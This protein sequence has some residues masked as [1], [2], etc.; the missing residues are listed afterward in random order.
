MVVN[1][2]VS[3]YS[4]ELV[5]FGY[6]CLNGFESV[7]GLPVEDF[8]RHVLIIGSTGSGKTTT[9]AI[10]ASQ[11]VRYGHV[12]IFDW[13]DEYLTIFKSLGV[14][15]VV[16]DDVKVPLRFKDFEELISIL[17][18]V[19]ELS[20]AQTYLLYRFLD[21]SDGDLTLYD[22]V[23]YLEGLQVESKWMAET[24]T[25]LL[26]KLKLIYNSKTV[27][28][29]QD[30]HPLRPLG[31]TEHGGYK[32]R[33]TSLNRFKDFKL[34]RL[35]A[36]TLLK[37]IEDFKEV[38]AD[39]L[40]NVFI[41]IDEAHHIANS[42]LMSRLVAE[43]RKLGVGLILITQSPSTIGNEILANCNVKIVHTLK[44]N[45][46]IEVII[47]SLGVN[48]LREVLPRLN[49]GEVFVDSPTL[50]YVARVKIDL[51]TR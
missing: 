15:G 48:E 47:K 20:D 1:D 19:L 27:G 46:D 30:L 26:R 51:N 33:I 21:E 22:L 31:L 6:V 29:Y 12:L 36:L 43:I 11:I 28:L 14:G 23:N 10:I 38:N 3:M 35:A 25:A 9:A 49:V 32:I 13:N 7:F 45:S 41:F 24:K 37:L 50:K 18:D 5:R 34:R 44:S 42:S 40:G 39:E 4:K 2:D 16:V 8:K 17:N